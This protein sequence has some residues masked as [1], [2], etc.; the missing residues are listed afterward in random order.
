MSA[1]KNSFNLNL[2]SG[3][4]VLTGRLDR[5]TGAVTIIDRKP[6]HGRSTCHIEWDADR[7]IQLSVFHKTQ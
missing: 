5:V 1:T 2:C 6:V 4:E 7:D 3:S